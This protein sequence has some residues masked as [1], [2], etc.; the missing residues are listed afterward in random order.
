MRAFG[1]LLLALCLG[2]PA[3]AFTAEADEAEL[4]ALLG[5]FLDGAS[6]SD[7]ATHARFWAED[8]VYTSSA[9][10]RFGKAAILDGLPPEPTPGPAR[11]G[12]EDVN[13]RIEGDIAVVTFRLVATVDEDSRDTFF[14]TGVF[15]KKDGE[16]RAFTWQATRE[17][18][19]D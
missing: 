1:V 4:R 3:P 6:R 18:E 14:N 17:A 19:G 11:Y 12:A 9:G 13:V 2:W 16:W 8:L 7:R 10:L 5:S 15:R